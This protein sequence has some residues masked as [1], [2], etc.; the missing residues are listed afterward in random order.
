V[1]IAAIVVVVVVSSSGNGS[2]KALTDKS[3]SNTAVDGA[4]YSEKAAVAD[5]KH[6]LD[7]IP[8]SANTLGKPTAPVTITE[9]GDLVCPTCAYFA[10]TSEPQLISSEVRTG[11]VQLQFRGSESASRTANNSEYPATQVAARAAG[12]QGKE[13]YYIMLTYDEQ[14]ATINGQPA[15]DV[16]YVNSTLLARRAEQVPG[17]HLKAWQTALGSPALKQYVTGDIAAARQQGVTGTPTIFISGPKGTVEYD[18][19][20]NSPTGA[21][22]TLAELQSLITQV[23]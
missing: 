8:E 7:G 16:S 12:L 2:L 9:Y 5:V 18:K 20:N 4:Q 17:L 1:V 23:S 15:E 22:P 14:P 19:N 10:L 11:K 21:V 13:W 3:L 6:L